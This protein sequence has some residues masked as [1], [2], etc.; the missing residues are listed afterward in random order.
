MGTGVWR[1][2]LKIVYRNASVVPFLAAADTDVA[3]TIFHALA[4]RGQ[5]RRRGF[6]RVRVPLA[7]RVRHLLP[8]AT[9]DDGAPRRRRRVRPPTIRRRA[10]QRVHL[11]GVQHPLLMQRRLDAAVRAIQPRV[12]L[13]KH[14]ADPV[15]EGV[16]RGLDASEPANDRELDATLDELFI[17]RVEIFCGFEA[18]SD[19]REILERFRRGVR[20]LRV[21]RDGR[22]LQHRH[23]RRRRRGAGVP[24]RPR[25]RRGRDDV[26]VARGSA[27]HRGAQHLCQSGG[28]A[29]GRRHRCRR[30]PRVAVAIPRISVT[31]SSELQ[32]DALEQHPSSRGV[33]RVRR[34][35]LDEERCA[36]ARAHRR[37]ALEKDAA[38]F[39]AAIAAA[40]E[41]PR[42]ASASRSVSDARRPGGFPP[43]G[44]GVVV[45][46]V[47][48]DLLP[49]RVVGDVVVVVDSR[50]RRS[51]LA[52]EARPGRVFP[53]HRVRAR[54]GRRR[55]AAYR[56]DILPFFQRR[57]DRVQLDRLRAGHDRDRSDR[58]G[59]RKRDRD[60][61]VRGRFRGEALE[62]ARV[63]G[64]GRDGRDRALEP[65]VERF[66]MGQDADAAEQR[67][68]S[69]VSARLGGAA[70]V[71]DGARVLGLGLGDGPRTSRRF[72]PRRGHRGACV[73]AS[74]ARSN[75]NCED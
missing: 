71:D 55:R 59:R 10:L 62:E 25:R 16:H 49:C 18:V 50:P 61:A 73:L 46:V 29:L 23:Q 54:R 26:E 35:Q 30:V 8:L 36:F 60:L 2:R 21:P 11:P 33:L 66:A 37:G 41:Y 52:D 19:R 63:R 70:R 58:R 51:T 38:L 4:S 68:G 1:T 40:T 43:R 28:D 12:E 22:H 15:L 48:T 65:A 53:T 42:H 64:N 67:T 7:S 24:A 6:L 34:E 14:R 57:M 39:S 69:R 56:P 3:L 9:A 74:Q 27:S 5:P 31:L 45:V 47:E 75:L 32:D 20:D 17:A 13:L 44:Q 72:H